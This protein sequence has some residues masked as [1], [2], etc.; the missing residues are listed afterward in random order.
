MSEKGLPDWAEGEDLIEFIEENELDFDG[1]ALDEGADGG[2][3]AEVVD[4]GLSYVTTIRNQ[5]KSATD[6]TGAFDSIKTESDLA[7]YRKGNESEVRKSHF[8]KHAEAINKA[9]GGLADRA[10]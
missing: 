2:Y 5:I 7:Q 3:G 10:V 4:R 9:L 1:L 8:A 6:N